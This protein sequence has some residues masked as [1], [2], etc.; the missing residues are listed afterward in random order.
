MPLTKDKPKCMVELCGKPLLQYQLNALQNAEI[1]DITAVAGYKSDQI[2]IK[3]INIIRNEKFASTN[4]VSTLFVAEHIMD[5]NQGLIISYGDIVYESDVIRDLLCCEAPVC[6][7]VDKGWEAYW[8]L[9]MD[10]PLKDAETL[11]IDQCG[12]IIELGKKP[13]SLEEIQGQYI[14]LIKI[15]MD[16]VQKLKNVYHE[17]DKTADYD[18]K[19]FDNMYMTSFLQHL[20]D[21]GWYVK[22]VFINHGWLEIDTVDDLSL[23][24]KMHMQGRLAKLI[25]LSK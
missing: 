20:I 12:R 14:G 17:M 22:P 8:R 11:K 9:R 13:N 2:T 6:V 21:I 4:M 23:Y 25:N 18:G 7:V 1:K 16:H 3:N 24:H 15:R 10:D 19:N 5:A